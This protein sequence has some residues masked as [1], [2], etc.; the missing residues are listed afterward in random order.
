MATRRQM[1]IGFAATPAL[2]TMSAQGDDAEQRPRELFLEAAEEI[3]RGRYI[4]AR[5][6]LNTLHNTYPESAFLP[7]VRFLIFFSY[8][9]EYPRHHGGGKILD[10]IET[11]LAELGTP[12]AASGEE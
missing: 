6:L 10:D 5:L 11:F 8:A 7:L 2:A 4:R 3:A 9:R 12:S 1:L